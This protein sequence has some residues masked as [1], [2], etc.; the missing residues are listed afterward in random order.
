M[1]L[2]CG[3]RKKRSKDSVCLPTLVH[4]SSMGQRNQA[5]IQCLEQSSAQR[6]QPQNLEKLHKDHRFIDEATF[7]EKG[8]E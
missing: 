1:V 8:D 3:K 2:L 5:S 4:S 6:I 7:S